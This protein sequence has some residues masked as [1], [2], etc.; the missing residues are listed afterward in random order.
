MSGMQ[1]SCGRARSP[2]TA[3]KRRSWAP[4]CS[5][6]ALPVPFWL[7][8]PAWHDD[9]SQ[10]LPPVGGAA[11]AAVLCD[12]TVPQRLDA[13]EEQGDMFSSEARAAS[14]PRDA[15]L[16]LRCSEREQLL[17]ASSSLS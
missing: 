10:K 13:R 6:S 4:D 12:D 1:A 14:T 5:K 2:V 3:A 16:S 9:G 15:S 11:W 17:A 8:R 7:L